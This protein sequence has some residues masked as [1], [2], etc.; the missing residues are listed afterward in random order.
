MGDELVLQRTWFWLRWLTLGLMCGG[1]LLQTTCTTS[2]A[3][4]TAGLLSS[5]SNNLISNYVNK[6]MGVESFGFSLGT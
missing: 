3:A 2:L 1:I 5:V 6:A 4:G